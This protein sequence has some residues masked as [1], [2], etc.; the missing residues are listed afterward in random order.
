M[1]RDTADSRNTILPVRTNH[2]HTSADRDQVPRAHHRRSSYREMSNQAAQLQH[3]F[4]ILAKTW[5]KSMGNVDR[6][7]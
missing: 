1:W 3:H 7:Y 6:F 4:E 2:R 5:K